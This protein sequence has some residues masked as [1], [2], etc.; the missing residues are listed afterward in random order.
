MEEMTLI[1]NKFKYIF[2]SCDLLK[3]LIDIPNKEKYSI[4]EIINII[5]KTKE[6]INK[7]ESNNI[8]MTINK[9]TD[10]IISGNKSVLSNN[11][12]TINFIL[13]K[14]Q[15]SENKILHSTNPKKDE[16]IKKIN[17][18]MIFLRNN[19]NSNNNSNNDKNANLLNDLMTTFI[20]SNEDI[21]ANQDIQGT[22]ETQ[23][24][25]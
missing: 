1:R 23:N 8:D 14:N 24:D 2:S 13:N 12:N 16:L 3:D 6:T 9:I 11:I 5:Y 7:K 22:Q 15:L 19:N 20:K 21:Q 10:H 4:M 25:I 18:L 17:N